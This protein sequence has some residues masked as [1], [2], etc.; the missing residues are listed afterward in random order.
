M[1]ILRLLFIRNPLFIRWL[2]HRFDFYVLV[3]LLMFKMSYI[4]KCSAIEIDDVFQ[5]IA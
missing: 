3:A 1:I 4:S 2:K 5:Y